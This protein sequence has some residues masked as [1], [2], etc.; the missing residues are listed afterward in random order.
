[1]IK[2]KR[3]QALADLGIFIVGSFVMI[4]LL[5]T[6]LFAYGLLSDE[7]IDQNIITGT[8]GTVNISNFSAQTVGKVNT[9]FLNGADLIGVIFLFALALGLMIAGYVNRDQTIPFFLMIDFIILIFG[10]IIAV[11]LANSYETILPLLPF[12]DIIATNLS[13]TSRLMLLLPKL[14]V[15]VGIIVM[16]ISYAGIP[17]SRG[18]G[19]VVGI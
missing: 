3:G 13:N 2:N 1:M 6:G 12:L 15:A 4:L 9:A 5:G 18:G 19:Q 17:K 16:I 14:T 11:Y 8:D 7:I 10:Y